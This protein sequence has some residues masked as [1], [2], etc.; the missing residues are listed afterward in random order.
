MAIFDWVYAGSGQTIKYGAATIMAQGRTRTYYRDGLTTV[1]P[2]SG[3]NAY[4]NRLNNRYLYDPS[5]WNS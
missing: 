2:P 5:G 4:F 3:S 1:V